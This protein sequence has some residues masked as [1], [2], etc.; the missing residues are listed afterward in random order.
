MAQT[1][2][3]AIAGNLA[4]LARSVAGAPV[5]ADSTTLTDANFDPA[6]GVMCTGWR[7]VAIF[8]R[9]TAAGATTANIQTLVRAGLAPSTADSW[10]VADPAAG[11]GAAASGQYVIVDVMGRLIFPRIHAVTGAPTVVAIWVAGWEPM[12]RNERSM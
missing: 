2:P 7:S 5:V 1:N 11:S 10:I 3:G 6:A 9:L 12:H 4:V 8:C